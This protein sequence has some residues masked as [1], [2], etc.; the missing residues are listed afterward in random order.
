M[1]CILCIIKAWAPLELRHVWFGRIWALM[2]LFRPTSAKTLTKSHTV[3]E[4]FC[5]NRQYVSAVISNQTLLS[6]VKLSRAS[7]AYCIW[8]S[9][10]SHSSDA[11]A[12]IWL[13]AVDVKHLFWH[14]GVDRRAADPSMFDLWKA[15]P[16]CN[17]FGDNIMG[18]RALWGSKM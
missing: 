2:V 5:A 10:L 13:V 1:L 12:N 4:N 9:S 15:A 3:M 17:V 11:T 18:N 7:C 6:V 8:K 16:C 14:Q